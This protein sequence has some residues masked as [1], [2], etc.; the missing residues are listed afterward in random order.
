MNLLLINFK[1]KN[2]IYNTLST[3]HYIVAF[4]LIKFTN[5]YILNYYYDLLVKKYISTINTH[6]HMH[7]HNI[8]IYIVNI[9]KL[10]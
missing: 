2:E 4:S 9:R 3:S 8:C 5:V 10:I 7:T 6:R 1:G